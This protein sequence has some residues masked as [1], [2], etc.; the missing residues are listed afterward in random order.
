[1]DRGGRANS[2]VETKGCNTRET[3]HDLQV[4]Q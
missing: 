4:L 2:D 3:R 1:M